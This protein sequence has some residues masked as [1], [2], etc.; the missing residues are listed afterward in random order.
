MK[1]YDNAG[2][3]EDE[4]EYFSSVEGDSENEGDFNKTINQSGLGFLN[5]YRQC[6]W[7]YK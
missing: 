1:Q 7:L 2:M 5:D 3:D 6:R 4:G